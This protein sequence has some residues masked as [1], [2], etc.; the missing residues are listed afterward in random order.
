MI[1][2]AIDENDGKFLERIRKKYKSDMVDV[3]FMKVRETEKCHGQPFIAVQSSGVRSYPRVSYASGTVVQRR[4]R[5]EVE[6]LQALAFHFSIRHYK[7]GDKTPC[8]FC[9]KEK[10]K[11]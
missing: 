10:I 5:L 11:E 9:E 6:Y 4:I 3:K 8:F 2:K 7:E 1:Q